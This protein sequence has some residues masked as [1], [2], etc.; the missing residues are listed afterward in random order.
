M[1]KNL[2]LIFISLFISLVIME[3]FLRFFFPQELTSPFRV[4]GKDGLLLNVKN[5]NGVH[6]LKE[7]KVNYKFGEYHNRT[8]NFEDSEKKILVLGDSFTFGWLL[9]DEDTYVYKLNKEFYDYIIINGAAGGWGTSDH[10][11]YLMEFCN[12]IK[13]KY[14]IIFINS[15]DFIRSKISNL[16]YL[17]KDG[18]LKYGKNKTYR[19]EKLTENFFYKI[20]V[21]NSH[22]INFLRKEISRYINHKRS[23]NKIINNNKE[24]DNFKIKELD[25]KVKVVKEK[26]KR[27]INDENFLFEKK[28]FLKIKKEVKK[29][30]SRLI[31]IN[32]GWVDYNED[33]SLGF[34]KEAKIFF[35]SHSI[36]F[37]D[38]TNQMEFVRNNEEQYIIRND[39][40]PN[41]LANQIIYKLVFNKIKN[42]ID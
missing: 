16:F 25:D 9:K 13:P 21:E 28:L 5:S 36:E 3:F 18:N 11:K 22:L 30:E 37:V 34:L 7:R 6:F 26:N 19:I 41:E 10:L 31:L 17:D 33:I 32:L 20:I 24:R 4:I 12:K 1:K 29:C 38:L 23:S 39:G 14:T 42:L 15:G 8:Y 40:H 35:K 27:L 2:L